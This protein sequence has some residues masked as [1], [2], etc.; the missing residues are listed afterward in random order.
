MLFA[1]FGAV[2]Q[3]RVFKVCE[4]AKPQDLAAFQ[5]LDRGRIACHRPQLW[6]L[7]MYLFL[8]VHPEVSLSPLHFCFPLGVCLLLR[9]PH[10]VEPKYFCRVTY[11]LKTRKNYFCK[12]V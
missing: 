12:A 3:V 4:G 2:L 10:F 5:L 1:S 6:E 8:V 9:D 11:P 7:C